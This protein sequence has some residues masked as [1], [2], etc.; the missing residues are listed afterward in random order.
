MVGLEQ[1]SFGLPIFKQTTFT[2]LHKNMFGIS[3]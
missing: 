1:R 3:Q 2:P